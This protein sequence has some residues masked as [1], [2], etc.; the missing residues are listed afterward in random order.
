[1]ARPKKDLSKGKRKDG[2]YEYK[3]TI[4][5]KMDGKLIRKS[6]YSA[7]SLEDAKAQHKQYL[8]DQK[9][10]EITGT[11]FTPTGVGFTDWAMIWLETYKKPNVDENTYR[12]TYLNSVEKHI[13]P[14]FKNADLRTIQ[15][16]DIQKYYSTKQHLSKSMLDKINMCL[17]GIFDSAIENDKCYKNPARAK[18]VTYTS[19]REKNVKHVYTEAQIADVC[20][21]C[22]LPEITA[23]LYTGMRRGEICGLMWSDIDFEAG[24]YTVNRSIADKKGGG[25]KTNPPKWK[26]YRTNP[27]EKEF[28]ALLHELAK[29]KTSMYVFP[30]D[31]GGVQSPNTMSQ[32]V[33]RRMAKLPVTIPR[34]TPHELRHT[35]GTNLRRRGVDIYSIQK[36]MGHKDIKM[37]TELYVHNEV[38]E[39]Q[40]A[41][42]LAD[43]RAARKNKSRAGN[44]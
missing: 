41:I 3:G 28:A 14:Y 10:A 18:N 29:N 31:E 34:L 15:P 24:T 26:S 37:T 13:I 43:Q 20:R 17:V 2:L 44:A 4:G 39:L 19:E 8:I 40:K 35:Y 7:I 1:M 38:E 16:A 25:V 22:D 9:A 23:M 36:I 5:R 6:F 27:L 33:A 32:K 11:V 30:N 12:L 21:I 42:S